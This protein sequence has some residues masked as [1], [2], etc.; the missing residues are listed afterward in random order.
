[1]LAESLW[2]ERKIDHVIPLMRRAAA[3]DRS[4][5]VAIGFAQEHQRVFTGTKAQTDSTSVWFFFHRVDRRAVCYFYLWDTDFGPAFIKICACFPTRQDQ[6]LT[7]V[8]PRVEDYIA[9]ARLGP[10]V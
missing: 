9:R 6:T 7:V 8:D 1:V 3:T 4:Q 2:P 10:A 5:V